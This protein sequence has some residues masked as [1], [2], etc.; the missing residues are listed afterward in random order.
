LEHPA[1]LRVLEVLEKK[2]SHQI[3]FID[4][5]EKGH[6]SVTEIEKAIRPNTILMTFMRANNETGVLNPID[7]IGQ[8]AREKNVFFHSDC[9]QGLGKVPVDVKQSQVMSA[10]FSGDKVGALEGVGFLYLDKDFP[11]DPLIVGGGQE[12]GRRG[13]TE[14]VIGIIAL[15][16]VCRVIKENLEETSNRSK[17]L[18]DKLEHELSHLSGFEVN[19]DRDARLPNT[20]NGSFEGVSGETLL[21]RLDQEGIAVSSGSACASGSTN[22]SHV[23]LGMGLSK[24]RTKS[25]IRFSLGEGTTEEEIKK[26]GETVKRIVED[27]RK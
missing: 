11:L 25:S 20:L 3:T 16:A 27:L 7:E 18:R 10:S 24:E 14:N 22:P 13:G 8:L 5:D 26:T 12:Q 21:L 15:G 23:L 19:G 2:Y 9:V 1:I 6:L 4:S 17:D